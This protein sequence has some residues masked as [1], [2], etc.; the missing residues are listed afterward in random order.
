[1]SPTP[2]PARVLGQRTKNSGCVVRDA[3]PG[4]G[5]TPG[6]VIATATKEQICTPG[7]S[8]KVR[9]VSTSLKDQVYVE[10]GIKQH[11]PGEYEADHLASLEM[12]H[13]GVRE[14]IVVR[15]IASTNLESR[16]SDERGS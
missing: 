14:V 5:Y 8:S 1:M 6:G 3:L 7:Y 11:S 13:E 4:A 2:L 16:I 12:R 15:T 10:Y 9:D